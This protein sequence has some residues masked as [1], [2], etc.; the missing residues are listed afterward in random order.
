MKVKKASKRKFDEELIE[1]KYEEVREKINENEGNKRIRFL[2]PL[3]TK[4]GSIKKQVIEEDI[5]SEEEEEKFNENENI[6]E[7]VENDSDNDFIETFQMKKQN[8]KVKKDMSEIELMAHRRK[9]LNERKIK[10]GL[11]A[12]TL[13]ENPEIK[14]KNFTV[15]L[16]FMEENT[17]EKLAGKLRPKKGDHRIIPEPELQLGEVAITCMCDLLATHPYFNY[18]SNIVCFLIPYLNNKYPKVREIV[19]KCF[20][21][22]FKEDKKLELTLTIVRKLNQLIKAKEYS[23]HTEA[24]SVLLSLRIRNVNLD[25]ERDEELKQKKLQNHKSRILALSKRERKRNKKLQEVEKELLETK[26][27]ENKAQAEKVLTEIISIVF[28]IYFKVIKTFPNSKI[29]SSC[30]EGLA[31]FAHCINLDFYQDLV[32]AINKLLANG[33]LGLRERLHCIQTVFTILSGHG[34]SLTIDPH[35][36]YL[37]LYKI[38]PDVHMARNEENCE[39]LVHCLTQALIN[40]RKRVTQARLNSFIKKILTVTLQLQHHGSLGLLGVVRKLLQLCKT[41]EI[42]LD[43]DSSVGEGLYQPELD[44]PEYCNAH[45]TAAWELVALQRHYHSIVQKMAKNLACNVPTSGEGSLIAEIAKLS[46]EELY[47]QYNPSEVAF[48]PP[49]SVP[50][51]NVGKYSI[52]FRGHFIDFKFSNY[53]E[54][55]KEFSNIRTNL[56]F[57]E[58][59]QIESAL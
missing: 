36:F 27:E 11:T 2:L 17:P 19:A 57:Y 12:S 40:R 28:T 30:L 14:V 7:E 59:L 24:L 37:H 43:T 5:E 16:D 9:L 13:L 50:K 3:K 55:Y 22:I 52:T 46:A 33:N 53:I 20:S 42:L 47:S 26:A 54:K 10:I 58:A 38:L 56:D 31:K 34:S 51:K 21:Q 6:E 44:D 18:S 8:V 25:K 41:T 15:L 1:D 48:N 23:L 39:I 49:V 32:N 45:R 29:L 35:R 4:D